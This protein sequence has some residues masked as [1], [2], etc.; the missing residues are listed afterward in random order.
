M[1]QHLQRTFHQENTRKAGYIAVLD[2]YTIAWELN[3]RKISLH[4]ARYL[5]KFQLT[6]EL[7]CMWVFKQA[8]YQ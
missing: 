4:N 5:L 3:A 2:I 8:I 7:L 1:Q 6:I